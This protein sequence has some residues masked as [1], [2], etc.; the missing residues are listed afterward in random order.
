MLTD[1]IAKG[2]SSGKTSAGGAGAGK[3][4]NSAKGGGKGQAKGKGKGK[5]GGGITAGNGAAGT[6][7]GKRG[8]VQATYGQLVSK[9]HWQCGRADCKRSVEGEL[10]RP[11]N[12]FCFHCYTPKNEAIMPKLLERGPQVKWYQDAKAVMPEAA[13][14]STLAT[15]QI[16]N[17]QAAEK[18]A[19][20]AERAATVVT[21]ELE[22][23]STADSTPTATSDVE[24]SEVEMMSLNDT[25][26]TPKAPQFPRQ[27]F[28]NFWQT[29]KMPTQRV[30]K[31]PEE[32]MKSWLCP[33][34]SD[35]GL[36]TK[37]Q[38]AE[39]MRELVAYHRKWDGDQAPETAKAC[40]RLESAEKELEKAMKVVSGSMANVHTV[41]ST[42]ELY[43]ADVQ[44]QRV[45]RGETNARA[46]TRMTEAVDALQRHVQEV[47]KH[48]ERIREK[49][50]ITQAG[51]DSFYVEQDKQHEGIVAEFDKAIKTAEEKCL[52]AKDDL[53]NVGQIQSCRV[54]EVDS[55]DELGT[56]P[57]SERM[58]EWTPAEL[59]TV[60]VKEEHCA[61]FHGLF[62]RLCQWSQMPAY[63]TTFT[64]LLEGL[65]GGAGTVE[66]HILTLSQILGPVWLRAYPVG[67][68]GNALVP[69]CL[70]NI[71]TLALTMIHKEF[72]G[73]VDNA[74]DVQNAEEEKFRAALVK[75]G[76]KKNV[77]VKKLVTTKTVQKA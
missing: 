17:S 51:W 47:T 34:S 39:R 43:L 67:P 9:G 29:S 42:K 6:A 37:Q 74:K 60:P 56:V 65:P 32:A 49:F 53:G 14:G 19:R 66:D 58:I 72:M 20:K 48:I 30:L 23:A 22:S 18:A 63:P 45:R 61:F 71:L 21:G 28:D 25:T 59:P 15:R 38:T 54:D 8:G 46:A 62:C 57:E 73:H 16:A 40:N 31:D 52:S 44:T 55:D 7:G 77:G 24:A 75:K 76:T 3:Q 26:S 64:D 70:G 35:Q 4:T 13:D 41:R 33:K 12:L 1:V 36:S 2:K 68:M 10:N 69:R 27:K 50:T 5:G 11:S